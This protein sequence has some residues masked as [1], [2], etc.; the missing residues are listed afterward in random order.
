MK[1]FCTVLMAALLVVAISSPTMAQRAA[2]AKL[3]K[4]AKKHHS[5]YET[6]KARV[7]QMIV[8]YQFRQLKM[9][10]DR[11]DPEAR[12]LLLEYL[13]QSPL[14]S[15]AGQ[16]EELKAAYEQT[17]AELNA[18]LAAQQQQLEDIESQMNAACDTRLAAAQEQWQVSTQQQLN[19]L[20]A[21]CQTELETLTSQLNTACDERLAQAYLDWQAEACSQCPDSAASAT[22]NVIDTGSVSPYAVDVNGSGEIYVLDPNTLSVTIFGSSGAQL[23]QWQPGTLV[24]P[25]DLAIDSQGNLYILDEQASQPLQKFS[26]DGNPMPLM[27]CPFM[28]TPPFGL[29]I[30]SN[31]RIYLS[32]QGPGGAGGILVMDTA[33]MLVQTFAQVSQLT[34]EAYRDLVV[35]ENSQ[36]VYVLTSSRVARFYLEGNYIDSWTGDFGLSNG[37]AVAPNGDLFIADTQNNEIDHYDSAGALIESIANDTNQPSRMVTD[38]AGRL[39]VA[40]YGNHQVRIID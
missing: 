21:G 23:G 14:P 7:H 5:Y 35:D 27:Q 32:G 24:Q 12:Q 1:K 36:M 20:S 40:D 34:G 8:Q 3:N 4:T 28:I 37:I 6:W 33:G 30:S 31:D 17:I 9:K 13:G 25:V 11:A 15:N 18:T 2:P 29:F 39:F 10:Y 26:P 16:I 19:E 38:A 22:A